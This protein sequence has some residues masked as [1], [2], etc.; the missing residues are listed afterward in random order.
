MGKLTE[1][2]FMSV[3]ARL[4]NLRARSRYESI[5]GNK[6]SALETFKRYHFLSDSIHKIAKTKEIARLK[7]WNELEQI[8]SEKK[9]LQFE[10][11]K[12]QLKIIALGSTIVLFIVLFI[13][14]SIWYYKPEQKQ[15]AV[16]KTTSY[17][18]VARD[19]KT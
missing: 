4:I 10:K 7:M 18:G 9:I 8:D 6:A 15:K 17:R 1:S 3:D 5:K 13:L 19:A 14:F 11:A 16:K 12:Q 2:P